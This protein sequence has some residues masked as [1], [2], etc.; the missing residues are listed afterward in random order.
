MAGGIFTDKPFEANIKCIL[1]SGIIIL[2]YY[3]LTA[4]NHTFNPLMTIPIFIISYVSLAWYDHTYNCDTTL[5][6]GNSPIGAGTLDSVFKP[7]SGN[8]EP[9]LLP[10][11]EKAYKKKV[12]LFHL[13]AVAPLIIYVGYNR[14]N[15][16]EKVYPLLLSTGIVAVLYHGLRL[17]QVY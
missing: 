11:Q 16:N 15:T 10:D 12:Y 1:Y 3:Y 7:N 9:N 5:K 13:L 2:L 8:P 14:K 17:S 4:T 6:T